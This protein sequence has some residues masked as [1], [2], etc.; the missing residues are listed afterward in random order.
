MLDKVDAPRG[1][2]FDTT[3]FNR[4][5]DKK[6]SIDSLPPNIPLFVTHIQLDEIKKTSNPER[7]EQLLDV[8]QK[9]PQEHIPTEG[10]IFDVSK[11]DVSKFGNEKLIE[12]LQKANPKHSEDALIGATCIQNHCLLVTDDNKLLNK[13]RKEGGTAVTF[14]DYLKQG[15]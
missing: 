14:L 5:L 6:I 8:F 11:F 12:K 15:N 1:A 3:V 9:V 13:V 7:R 2:M 10:G 4:I